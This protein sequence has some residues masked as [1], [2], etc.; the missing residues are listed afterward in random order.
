MNSIARMVC[1]VLIMGMAAAA[2]GEMAVTDLKCEYRVNPLG[3]DAGTP[4]LSW[5]MQSA[6]R[7]ARQ[8]AYQI[9]VAD[10][11][12]ALNA[13]QGARWDSGKV[14]SNASAH[15]AYAGAPLASR[16]VCHW[17]VRVWDESG[18]ASA[19]SA[20]ALWTMGL[21][22]PEDWTGKWIGLDEAPVSD[23]LSGSQWIWYPEGAPEKDAPVGKRYFRHT[24]EIAAGQTVR[25]AMAHFTGDNNMTLHVNGQRAGEQKSFNAAPG[26][27]VT[28]LLHP[29]KNTL[30]VVASNEGDAANPA[31]CIGAL[32]IEFNGGAKQTVVT[33]GEWRAHNDSTTGWRE[34]NFGDAAWKA[35]QVLGDHGMAPWNT[36]STGD[37]RELLARYLRR[38]FNAEKPVKRATAHISGLGLFEL[39]VNGGKVG[40][41]VL[42]PGLTEYEKRTF[43]LTYDVTEQV[44]AG[45]NAIGVILGNG[46]YYAPRTSVPTE[47]RTYGFPKLM[48]D[49]EVEY[50]DGAKARVVSDESWKLSTGGPVRINNEY[51]GE[52]YDARKEMA[53][54]AGAGYDD[55]AW[56][57]AQAVD[58]PSGALAAQTIAPI[59][60]METLQPVAVSQPKPGVHIFDMGQNMVGWCRLQVQGPAG[61][62]VSLRHAEVLKEDGTL[63]LDNIRSAKVTDQYVLKGEGVETWEPRFTYHGFRYVEVTG[64]PGEPGL[65]ALQGQVVYDNVETVGHFETSNALL[66]RIYKNVY[67]GVRGN[68]R[69][70]PTDCPQRDERQAWLGDRS[71]ESRGEAYIFD[72]A[73]LYGKWVQDMEDSQKENGSVSDVSPSYWPLYN[74]NVTW[75]SSFILIPGM[76]Y[77]QYGDRR[78]I[79]DRYEGMKRWI[80]H[81]TGYV[82]DGIIA[83][84]NYGDW[85][86]PPES[87]ELIHSKDPA[88]KTSGAVL[89]T[90][91]FIHDLKQMARYASILGKADDGKAFLAQADAM[92]QAFNAKFFDAEKGLYDNG[93]QT[94][95]VLPLAFG[96]VPEDHQKKLFEN[97]VS[98]I[99]EKTNSHIGTGLIGGQW[100]MRTLTENGR[101]DLAF[102]LATQ[103]GYP[104]W[105][106]MIEKD[107]TTIWE[108]WNGDTADPAMNSGN[109]VMLVG[110]LVIWFYEYLA[111]IR[112]A[113]DG[114]GFQK[115]TIEPHL[116]GDLRS[117]DA[118]VKTN[119]GLVASRWK[120][121]PKEFT[122]EVSVPANCTAE[123]SVPT[124]G[125][126]H[127]TIA[128]SGQT[129]FSD[130]AYQ[131]GVAGITSAGAGPEAVRFDVGAGN[132]AFVVKQ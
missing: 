107:A 11:L 66:N 42:V 92:T 47:T 94:S 101:P 39:Y 116:L 62:E 48:L 29:G 105:G 125:W 40:N 123:I 45:E 13:D 19:W 77:D 10:S 122:L 2:H 113:L 61:T 104:S 103:K 67:W 73:A 1:G 111:G 98:N 81:M 59:R 95:A 112:P 76:L 84:D 3:I 41:D 46:R 16:D 52:V 5:L 51:D 31:G 119:Y 68:Y 18:T 79:A 60:V 96:L 17:K 50:A 108:L 97:L 89:A 117:L 106:Y 12:E 38:E 27:D 115:L 102:T 36:V 44:K 69:S 64:F 28:A 25:R 90:S 93:T 99:T 85:C 131:P 49:L 54:W 58:G 109:H 7:G 75:P 55:S 71:A 8:T 34:E 74:D 88:R 53:G 86:V 6:V 129:V 32:R 114:S 91:Y 118:S 35:A 33:N 56:Q 130:R 80:A 22:A 24:F 4:R 43:Y 121:M 23:D 82:E 132:Y 70:F 20:P 21:L 120:T 100:L 37:S 110:D 57:A 128:E 126:V 9:L 63:Y 78:A 15:V 30:A 65:D 124:L 14:E 26:L 87:Q 83:K 127:A 72:I